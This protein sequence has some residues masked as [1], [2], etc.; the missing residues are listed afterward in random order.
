[1][2]SGN[3]SITKLSRRAALAV[4]I[5]CLGSTLAHAQSAQQLP[6]GFSL[7]SELAPDIQQDIRYRGNNSFLGRPVAGYSANECV[8]S[9][10]AANA[11]AEIQP[12]LAALGFGL[13]VYDCYRPQHAVDDFVEWAQLVFD[14]R[15]KASYYPDVPKAEL[16]SQ[17]YIAERSGHSR[18][19]TVDL[20]LVP[21]DSEQPEVDALARDYDCRAPVA[22][23]VPDNSLDMGTAYDCFDALSHTFNPAV[24]DAVLARRRML[25]NIMNTAGFDNYDQEWWHFTLRDEPFP[26]QY[27]D[28]ALPQHTGTEQ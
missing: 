25:V 20:T 16:F 10:E 4:G 13:K 5:A 27:F 1:M 18:G 14:Q 3:S 17:G 21:L 28:F 19:S 26:E 11:L 22:E 23:R 24:G 12:H 8:L 15:M 6:D 2:A 7:L 9:T